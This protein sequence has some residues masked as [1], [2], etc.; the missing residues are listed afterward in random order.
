MY[1]GHAVEYLVSKSLSHEFESM[2]SGHAVEYLY[3]KP[4]PY[5]FE[6]MYSGHAVEYFYSNSLSTPFQ[7]ALAL[8]RRGSNICIPPTLSGKLDSTRLA[9]AE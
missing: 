3:S 1:S 7:K 8:R 2:Y 6:S 5:E 9:K 4:L